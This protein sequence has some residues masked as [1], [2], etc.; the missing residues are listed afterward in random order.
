[1]PDSFSL[2]EMLLPLHI[3]PNIQASFGVAGT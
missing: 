1:L 2:T 3:A